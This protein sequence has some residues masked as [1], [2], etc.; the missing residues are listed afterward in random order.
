MDKVCGRESNRSLRKTIRCDGIRQRRNKH[1]P[2]PV[3]GQ[4]EIISGVQIHRRRNDGDADEHHKPRIWRIGRRTESP[5]RTTAKESLQTQSKSITKGRRLSW[6]EDGA[7]TSGP[8]WRKRTSICSLEIEGHIHQTLGRTGSMGH[9]TWQLDNRLRMELREKEHQGGA[10][11]ETQPHGKEM[12]EMF[13]V[14]RRARQSHESK[15]MG[16]RKVILIK[17]QRTS[18]DKA[19]GGGLTYLW[20]IFQKEGLEQTRN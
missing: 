4:M 18:W 12:Q 19:P 9:P 16:A 13:H 2:H 14:E 15:G 20:K 5:T 3:L 8:R 10:H 7:Q 6:K 1:P 11:Q 17:C